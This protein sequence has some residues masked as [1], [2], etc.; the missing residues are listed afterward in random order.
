LQV[1]D[2]IATITKQQFKP[3][4]TKEKGTVA[5]VPFSYMVEDKMKKMKNCYLQVYDN[6][7]MFH[8]KYKNCFVIVK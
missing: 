6:R 8:K 5:T 2:I 7:K 1:N 4:F 3:V